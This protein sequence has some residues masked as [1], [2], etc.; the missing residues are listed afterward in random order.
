MLSLYERENKTMNLFAPPNERNLEFK[1]YLSQ[2][3]A[4]AKSIDSAATTRTFNEQMRQIV[5]KFPYFDH[6]TS[7]IMAIAVHLVSSSSTTNPVFDR[8][9]AMTLIDTVFVSYRTKKD[10]TALLIDVARYYVRL[11]AIA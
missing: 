2:F 9:K 3:K 6:T 4:A 10:K 8:E 5:E 1:T 7:R 11:S